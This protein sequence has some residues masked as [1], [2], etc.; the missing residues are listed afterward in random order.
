VTNENYDSRYMGAS[1]RVAGNP[2]VKIENIPLNFAWKPLEIDS[3]KTVSSTKQSAPPQHSGNTSKFI[4][5][6]FNNENEDRNEDVDLKQ[7]GADSS[8]QLAS[9]GKN[10]GVQTDEVTAK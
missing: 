5:A 6:N 1:T 9:R 4:V 7:N 8:P 3:T 2:T 10:I